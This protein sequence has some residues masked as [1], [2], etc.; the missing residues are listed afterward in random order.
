[1]E[2]IIKLFIEKQYR[3]DM[4]KGSLS[5]R[6]TR[7]LG[8]K[9]TEEEIK[10]GKKEARGRIKYGLDYYSRRKKLP[11]ILIFDIETSPSISYTFGRFNYNIAYD[12][13]EQEPMILTWAA[14][15]LYSTEV[16]S[17][18][19]TAEEVLNADD[20]RI[21]KSLWDLIDEADI[22]VAHFGD[23]FDLPM[24]NTRSI[25]NGLPP[26]N[27]V[28][29]VDTKKVA[30]GVF[31]F[32]SNKL[33]ALAKYFGIPGKIDT[34]FQLWID[35]IKGKEEALEKMRVYNCMTPDH[36]VLNKKLKWVEIGT[37]KPGDTILGFDEENPGYN[38]ARRYKEAKVLACPKQE[39]DVYKVTLSNGEE[40][41]C[42]GEHLWLIPSYD[43]K[44]CRSFKWVKTIDLKFKGKSI[45]GKSYK[46]YSDAV[47]KVL[48]VTEE[49]LSKDAGWLSGMLDGEGCLSMRKST[50]NINIGGFSISICQ[51]EGAE[52]NKLEKLLNY[53]NRKNTNLL[54]N[55]F[56]KPSKLTKKKVKVI[57]IGGK[58]SEKIEFLSKIRPERLIS[59]IDFNSLPQI[60]S[61]GRVVFVENVEFLGKKEIVAL[62][63]DTKTYV[64]D[65]YLMHNCQDVNVLEEVYLK[66][67]P[68]IKSHP[69]VA[70]YLNTDE[71]GCS[72]CGSTE[73]TETDKYQYTNTGKFKLYRCKC[74]ALSRGRRTDVDK[75]RGKTLLTSVPR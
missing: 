4:G 57:H 36:K 43:G 21:V 31:K 38:R 52:L 62:E 6:F 18:K 71:R 56:R 47:V 42:T 14:K 48:D 11:K 60:E 69:N 40:L 1:M 41:K 72:A 46:D 66:L 33:D 35:C 70:V 73:L 39:Q 12:Q 5:K 54:Y 26:Y 13:V 50:E 16:M 3:L 75:T 32:P 28:R 30:S 2:E 68:Y 58:F 51:K 67:R 59:N 34:E 22:V 74:G 29:S 49:D 24:L 53:Y 37:L 17:D 15:W 65:G 23:R 64:A 20:Y 7:I 25:L 9:V 19:V 45:S 55:G 61:R 63:T 44:Q 10:E 8:R 27:T